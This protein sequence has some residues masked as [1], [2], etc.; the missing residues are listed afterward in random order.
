MIFHR[1]S[2]NRCWS[3]T[4]IEDGL[5]PWR[6]QMTVWTVG[7]DIAASQWRVL[8]TQQN[9]FY[10]LNTIQYLCQEIVITV[11]IISGV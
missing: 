5:G 3:V 11:I 8:V 9:F 4:I 2:E 10:N 7:D 6:L 1:L